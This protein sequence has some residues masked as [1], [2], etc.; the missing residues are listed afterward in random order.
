MQK[1]TE[2]LE[3]KRAEGTTPASEVKI[4]ASSK[5]TMV[6]WITTAWLELANKVEA[7]KSFLVTGISNV[8]GG[9][10]D[11]L[12][13]N[14]ELKSEI[15]SIMESV[16]GGLPLTGIDSDEEP[17]PLATDSDESDSEVEPL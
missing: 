11:E 17:D 8:L 6:D 12:M 9:Y 16:F 13:R 5:Q 10:E 7:M 3:R 2:E 14:D 15:D 1:S 4:P